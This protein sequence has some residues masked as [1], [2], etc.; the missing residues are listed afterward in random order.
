MMTTQPVQLKWWQVI[1][2]V[3][4]GQPGDPQRWDCS[5]RV[6]LTET[7]AYTLPQGTRRVRVVKGGA[8]ISYLRE[9]V[10]LRA[11]QMLQ[12]RTDRNGVV[13]TALGHRPLELEIYL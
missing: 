11:G 3:L 12:L 13:V 5:R 2:N 6:V 4:D 1:K 8:W 10:V 7:E 9:D